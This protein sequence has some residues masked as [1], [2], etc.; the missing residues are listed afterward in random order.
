MPEVLRPAD[1][2]DLGQNNLVG[3]GFHMP[4]V[5]LGRNGDARLCLALRDI[6][7]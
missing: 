3:L 2:R 7:R 1:D 6:W 4:S 5:R